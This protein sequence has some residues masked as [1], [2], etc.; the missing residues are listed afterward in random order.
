MSSKEELQKLVVLQ[1]KLNDLNAENVEENINFIENS[2]FLEDEDSI[3]VLLT[4]T[5]RMIR[6]RTNQIDVFANFLVGISKIEKINKSDLYEK[7][8]RQP[9]LKI[10]ADEDDPQLL[11]ILK[12][13]FDFFTDKE[14]SSV[15]CTKKANLFL[16]EFNEDSLLWDMQIFEKIKRNTQESNKTLSELRNFF[17]TK[18]SLGYALKYDNCDLLQKFI[19]DSFDFNKTIEWS[20][21]EVDEQPP[22]LSLLGVAAYYGSYQCF[23]F[24]NV[25]GAAINKEISQCAALG[26]NQQIVSMCQEH[27]DDSCFSYAFRYHHD[28]IM[29]WMQTRGEEGN[30]KPIDCILEHNFKYLIELVEKGIDIS[31]LEVNESGITPLILATQNAMLTV[32]QYLIDCGASPNACDR[33]GDSPLHFAVKSVDVPASLKIKT[34]QLLIKNGADVN[35]QDSKGMTPLM[36]CV[37]AGNL[38]IV[39]LLIENHADPSIPDHKGVTPIKR[40]VVRDVAKYLSELEN[41]KE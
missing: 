1:E 10:I 35:I 39:Q 15:N 38:P 13:K 24:I 21:F 18:N 12:N 32:I 22:S 31:T 2:I 25:N 11:Y 36:H 16:D 29:K 34:I 9:L 5:I 4:E 8:F 27:F 20:E 28:N 37:I 3:F 41:Q 33:R 40:A 17:W 30:I 26:G 6:I 19:N 23:S 7:I 14:L